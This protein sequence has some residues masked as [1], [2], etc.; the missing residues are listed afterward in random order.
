VTRRDDESIDNELSGIAMAAT[1]E[2][3]MTVT[4][5]ETEA[6]LSAVRS[7]RDAGD[8]GGA[9]PSISLS[10]SA[11]R[12]RSPLI[13]LGAAAAVV[14]LLGAGFVAVVVDGDSGDPVAEV[15]DAL[16]QPDEV[17]SA[18]TGA[19]ATI[20][21]PPSAGTAITT[22]TEAGSAN[23]VPS[24]PFVQ[25]TISVDAANPPQLLEPVVYA[26]VPLVANPNGNR[27]EFA[28]GADNVVV[29]QPGVS[30]FT[31][32]GPSPDGI[33]NVEV[34]TAEN[35]SSIVSGPG[36]VVY[37][38]GEPVFDEGNEAVPRGF[39]FVA[40]P[41]VGDRTGEV[42]AFEE[43]GLIDY[44][45]LPA[46][47]FG[48]GPDGVIA[49]ARVANVP[50]IGY[51]D[52]MGAPRGSG[53]R[54]EFGTPSPLL[55]A[56]RTDGSNG[57]VV[58]VLD[59]QTSWE[60]DVVR[61]PSYSTPF[62]GPNVVAPGSGGRVIYAE[63]IGANISPEEDFG[64]NAMP[65]VAVLNPDGSGEWY[66]LPDDW[67]VVA[68]DVWGTL[69]ARTTDN[70]IELARLDDLIPAAV[71]MPPQ[72]PDA[73][74]DAP[75]DEAA[76][77]S[78][79]SPE[80]VGLEDP[81][82]GVLN[83]PRKCREEEELTCTHLASTEDGR[84][85]AFDPIDS[86]LSIYDE[87]GDVLLQPPIAVAAF[88]VD[89]D[90]FFRYVGPDDV[91]YFQYMTP[92]GGDP[93]MDMIAVPL[94]GPNAG[95]VVMSWAGLDGTGD[96]TLIPRRAGLTSVGCCGARVA[97]PAPDA[98]IYRW[99]DRNG[100]V[101]ESTAPS[102][103]LTLG[104]AGASVTRI[105]GVDAFTRF[106]LPT[107]FQT[108]R[109]FPTIVATDD[110][111]ALAL[112]FLQIGNGYNVFVDF[113]TDWPEFAVDNGDVYFRRVGEERSVS[114]LER[115]GTVV[116]VADGQFVRRELGQVASAGWPGVAV[117]DPQTGVLIADG[118]NDYIEEAQPAW[119]NDPAMLGLQL[120]PTVQPNETVQVEIVTSGPG[121]VASQISIM[122][123]GFLDDSVAASQVVAT[124]VLDED[125][126]YRFVSATYGVR[127]QPGRGHQDFSTELCI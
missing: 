5:T 121:G 31:T 42:V 91:A 78:T 122:T 127:C 51:V 105:D 75:V 81:P 62:V 71:S 15:L 79:T 101:V 92:G 84:I 108:P 18:T 3:E 123:S 33:A 40:I 98:P 117:V 90:A 87:R 55:D 116:V 72:W 125:G 119:A 48:H 76:V 47:F 46:Y 39:R 8:L 80:N 4:D 24:A 60:L 52:E 61:S 45:E 97:R 124:V 12:R 88:P 1:H 69:L 107:A 10:R 38:L 96:S 110:G 59:S 53:E 16:E 126:V 56:E 111:G 6:A 112:D 68:S 14:A 95:T 114:L 25:Q 17:G 93:S 73:P 54:G 109:D 99:V 57:I 67:D 36:G 28:I 30:G 49:R 44:L 20:P 103:D 89:A 74:V 41:F 13:M 85:V 64:L 100:D 120:A 22:T 77:T 102:F 26:S 104:D 7:R 2:H 65:V 43:V 94:S 66:R 82:A 23:V 86:S 9:P 115:S 70:A 21:R 106:A 50:I 63:R 118:L 37:G 19:P 11:E 34:E 29:N 113:N 58:S 27:I 83:I 35:V 32:V